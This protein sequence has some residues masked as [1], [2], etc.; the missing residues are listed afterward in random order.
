MKTVFGL[1]AKKDGTGVAVAHD[2]YEIKDVLKGKGW[3]WNPHERVWKKS[4]TRETV[5]EVLRVIAVYVDEVECIRSDGKAGALDLSKYRTDVVEKEEKKAKKEEKPAGT[6]AKDI[7]AEVRAADEM[8]D[9][10]EREA[11][12]EQAGINPAIV[13]KIGYLVTIIPTSSLQFGLGVDDLIITGQDAFPVKDRIKKVGF[14]WDSSA[15]E[16]RRKNG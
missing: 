8:W 13:A 2:A 3:D 14:M 1:E 7:T 16:W 10:N 6:P 12:L 15:Q 11:A 5:D 4:F 9:A